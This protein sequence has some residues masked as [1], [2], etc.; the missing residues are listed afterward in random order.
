MDD[1]ASLCVYIRYEFCVFPPR[2]NLLNLLL[3]YF[4]CVFIKTHQSHN[5]PTLPP[6]NASTRK[7]GDLAS[8]SL[9][10]NPLLSRW[11]TSYQ[12]LAKL[13]CNLTS[14]HFPFLLE[15]CRCMTDERR[16]GAAQ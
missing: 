2:K 13:G 14:F 7:D 3:S 5:R 8:P 15:A 12:R 4:L 1:H 16:L 9:L 10:L 6:T 11:F